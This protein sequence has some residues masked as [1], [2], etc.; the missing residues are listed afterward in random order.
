MLAVM[1]VV[2]KSPKRN[3]CVGTTLII[4]FDDNLPI[5]LHLTY[6]SEYAIVEV[7]WRVMPSGLRLKISGSNTQGES[8]DTHTH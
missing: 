1:S 4:K 3:N 7:T 5:Y 2:C 6:S 8:P